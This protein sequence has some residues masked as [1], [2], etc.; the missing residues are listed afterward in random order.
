MNNDTQHDTTRHYNMA[1]YSLGHHVWVAGEYYLDVAG[2]LADAGS[3][4]LAG[5]MFRQAEEAYQW[6]NALQSGT[7]VDMGD[8]DYLV[9]VRIDRLDD[10]MPTER[11][12]MVGARV[13]GEALPVSP[14]H[15]HVELGSPE[16]VSRETYGC[17][18]QVNAALT[19]PPLSATPSAYNEGMDITTNTATAISDI[20]AQLISLISAEVLSQVT[21]EVESIAEGVCET[22]LESH[23]FAE[24]VTE[25]YDFSS[26]VESII[27]D[28]DFSDKV[29]AT[30]ND[31]TFS[32]SID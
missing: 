20:V 12:A 13:R 23:D 2:Q 16:N 4:E 27:S 32:V 31:V 6:A 28:Y 25:S 21:S 24:E 19:P 26:A 5:Q 1:G 9:G 10:W 18:V 22:M 14:S 3:M 8:C 11:V 7:I 15:E 29:H 17:S 30:L